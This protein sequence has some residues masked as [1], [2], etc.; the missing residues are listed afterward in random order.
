MVDSGAL[1]INAAKYGEV[2]VS[3]TP[4]QIPVTPAMQY[5]ILHASTERARKCD[6][7]VM[8]GI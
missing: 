7:K 2:F 1:L 3:I 8:K 4:G 5:R 6:G